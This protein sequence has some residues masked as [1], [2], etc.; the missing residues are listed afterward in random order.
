[1]P[2]IDVIRPCGVALV[3]LLGRSAAAADVT[4]AWAGHAD[5]SV[6]G[7]KLYVGAV[8]GSYDSYVDVG[9]RT[10]Y[11]MTGLQEGRLYFFAVTAYTAQ[12]DES[13][14]STEVSEIVP[15]SSV[16]VVHARLAPQDTS[17]SLNA[18]NYSVQTTLMTYTWPDRRVANAAVLKFDMSSIPPGAVV[19]VATL[20]LGLV[21]SDAITAEPYSIGVHKIVGANPV[22]GRATGYTADGINRWTPSGCCHKNV[23]MAQ[24]NISPAYD[25]QPIDTTAGTRIWTVTRLVQEWIADPAHN[26]G[27]LINADATVRAGR[28]RYF[29]SVEHPDAALRPVLEVVYTLPSGP[30]YP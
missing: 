18:T 1:M 10:S 27:L 28:Y 13:S 21:K 14:F 2:S 7:Y 22:I 4:I 5:A 6:A 11:T 9:A 24:A 29:A 19:Q 15:G 25:V 17:L 26:V 20:R 12:G 16:Q 23:P 8:S 3:L 30:W